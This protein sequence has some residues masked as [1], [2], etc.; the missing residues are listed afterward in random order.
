MIPGQL[1]T[2]EQR[3]AQFGGSVSG[4]LSTC[5]EKFQRNLI[6][7]HT[8]LACEK[9]NI[10]IHLGRNEL[11]ECCRPMD[12][13]DG[14]EYTE[15]FDGV[16]ITENEKIFINLKSVCGAGG[17]QTRTLREV[18]H[19]I[20]GQCKWLEQNNQSVYFANILDGDQA[21]RRMP[22]LKNALT[23]YDPEVQKRIY[24]G[25]L[26]SYFEWFKLFVRRDTERIP[27]ER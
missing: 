18:Y 9:T 26:N 1:I 3:I 4:K 19:F 6:E 16:Q 17:S 7:K 12:H 11:T 27:D 21:H 14:F 24:I 20:H 5:I 15:D 13:L 22:L 10:R 25:D 23:H 2:K 8:G